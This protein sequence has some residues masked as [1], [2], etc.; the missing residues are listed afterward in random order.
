MEAMLAKRTLVLI[1]GGAWLTSLDL[2]FATIRGEFRSGAA[3]WGMFCGHVLV[4]LC[5][6]AFLIAFARL[7]ELASARLAANRPTARVVIYATGFG[8]C[9][10]WPGALLGEALTEGDWIA[11]QWFAT[12]LEYGISGVLVAAAAALTAHALATRG[13]RF[14]PFLWLFAAAAAAGANR[15]VL[16]G[17]YPAF[18][19]TLY[20]ASAI[21]SLLA[22]DALATRVRQPSATRSLATIGSVVV[23][24]LAGSAWFMP[25]TVRIATL[26]ASPP[27][28]QV[29]PF[30]LP[31]GDDGLLREAIAFEGAWESPAPPRIT[32]GKRPRNA[33][34]IVVDTLRAD[35]LLPVDGPRGFYR[36][37]EDTPF[38]DQWLRS[39]FTFT[40][41]YS[42]A[43]RTNKSLP[44]TFYSLEPF[45]A[46]T[47]KS[48]PLAQRVRQLGLTPLAVV[49]EWFMSP[50]AADAATLLDGFDV[51]NAYAERKDQGTFLRR[52][53]RVLKDAKDQPFFLW[54][55]YFGM[56]EPYF[57]GGAK[58][59][60]T[61][62]SAD[63]YRA[64]L[65]YM[66]GVFRELIGYLERTGKLDETLIVLASDHGEL[67]GEGGLERHG[68][69]V[70]DEEVHVPLAFWVPGAGS[71]KIETL[72]GNID[73]VP[74]ILDLFGAAPSAGF[75]GRSLVP[76][77]ASHE[78]EST[79]SF[80]VV[81]GRGDIH[82]LI[83]EQHRLTYHLRSK[84]F[85]LRPR[86]EATEHDELTGKDPVLERSLKVE[87]ARRNPGVF[88]S[89]LERRRTLRE[90]QS[91]LETIT[92]DVSPSY[93][94]FLIELTALSANQE[95]L[96][97]AKA[98]YDRLP[99]PRH[100]V[101]M[102]S[103]LFA[104]EPEYWSRRF[105]DFLREY[106]GRPEEAQMVEELTRAGV[107]LIDSNVVLDRLAD[108]AKDCSTPI[109]RAWL[110]LL[111][112]WEK[113]DR[114][115]PILVD[116]LNC[117]SGGH[118]SEDVG[119][120]T[121]VLAGFASLE[122]RPRSDVEARILPLI[123]HSNAWI[124]DSA[125]RALGAIGGTAAAEKLE[126]ILAKSRGRR[127]E[128]TLVSLAK[129]RGAS[130]TPSLVERGK[131]RKQLYPVIQALASVGDERAIPFLETVSNQDRNPWIRQKAREALGAVK[132]RS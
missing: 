63:K 53:K 98:L 105:L 24:S 7:A 102:V 19:V 39:G 22:L 40:N 55:H 12:P 123:G 92:P 35:A 26:A 2:V 82:G 60:S 132:E 61:A 8:A 28:A 14:W 121:Q 115:V 5:L 48:V 50:N 44:P 76:A 66:D 47:R 113:N 34:L 96:D 125:L 128:A 11:Q 83:T 77:M 25:P 31:R 71:G 109:A 59:A 65:R 33:V 52:V 130:M 118:D 114:F 42:P 37:P 131:D 32:L 68:Q 21:L 110:D 79:R 97:A 127:L 16:A 120:V 23:L 54:L 45:E 80:Y 41:A 1:L 56:H 58:H 89:E 103:Q 29:L 85:S 106:R 3:T 69:G 67:L 94:T 51:I 112:T 107:G 81:S 73:V 86:L 93:L 91:K 104:T 108:L 74:T 126:G 116:F 17:L 30:L 129:I 101:A 4:L 87:F 9:A 43:S 62:S 13:R 15:Y 6:G 18:H 84:T 46:L 49:P 78:A 57:I 99:E 124:A 90:L 75:R 38:L 122:P 10:L 27:L 111:E 70:S 20:G 36:Q 88:A 72:A 119:L 64:A 117:A 95:V 100:R